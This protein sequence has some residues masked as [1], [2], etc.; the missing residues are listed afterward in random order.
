MIICD[1]T[2]EEKELRNHY[3]K[4]CSVFSVILQVLESKNV[5]VN[6]INSQNVVNNLLFS[7]I[8]HLSL[9]SLKYWIFVNN[10]F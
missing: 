3:E 5:K 8:C 4:I 7:G 6:K 1:L 10:H 9:T 2:L